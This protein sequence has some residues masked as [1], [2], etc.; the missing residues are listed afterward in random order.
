MY[1]CTIHIPCH[2]SMIEQ[3]E[4]HWELTGNP[5]G[6]HCSK[7]ARL[8]VLPDLKKVHLGLKIPLIFGRFLTAPSLSDVFY[9]K[10]CQDK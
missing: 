10:I 9:V 6:T 2:P 7:K 8:E 1:Y 4:I 3:S 5:P